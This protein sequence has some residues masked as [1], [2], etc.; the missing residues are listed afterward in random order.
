MFSF[1]ETTVNINGFISRVAKR[2]DNEFGIY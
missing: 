2:T 1:A